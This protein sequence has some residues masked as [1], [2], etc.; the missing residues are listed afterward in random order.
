[1]PIVF[2]STLQ[3]VTERLEE[4]LLVLERPAVIHLHIKRHLGKRVVQTIV[5]H[6]ERRGGEPT[7]HEQSAYVGAVYPH[8]ERLHRL[9]IIVECLSTDARF[10]GN[11]NHSDTAQTVPFSDQAHK[12][13]SDKLAGRTP[14][15]GFPI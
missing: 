7:P 8:D 1:M 14:R 15:R 13:L 9:E 4:Q 11:I 3:I 6:Q 10:A 5:R 2:S 12:R